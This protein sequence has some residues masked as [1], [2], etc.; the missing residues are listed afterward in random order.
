MDRPP[1]VKSIVRCNFDTG[2]VPPEMVK[3][4]RPVI[5]LARDFQLC[6]VVPCSTTPPKRQYDT[7]AYYLK[8]EGRRP[9]GLDEE[10]WVKAD[11]VYTVCLSR[12]CSYFEKSLNGNKIYFYP[13]VSSV[14]FRE[15]QQC[16]LK[17]LGLNVSLDKT[18]CTM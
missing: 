12:L 6:T 14:Q 7:N 5:V 11:L 4:G 10:M 2:F 13:Q 17:R 3:R 18:A 1:P 8:I 16:V 15:I 9:K